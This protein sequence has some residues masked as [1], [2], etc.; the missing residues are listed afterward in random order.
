M[1]LWGLRIVG[2]LVGFTLGVTL[3]EVVLA[4]SGLGDWTNAVPFVLAV[5]G[6]LAG[7]EFGLRVSRT[8]T[9]PQTSIPEQTAKR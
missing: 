9:A 8:A 5:V 1:R 2:I 6:W 3:T 7:S 4:G